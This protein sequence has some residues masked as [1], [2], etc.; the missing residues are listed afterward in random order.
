[1]NRPLHLSLLV[2]L[3]ALNLNSLLYPKIINTVGFWFTPAFTGKF[4]N[5]KFQYIV[6]NETR[7]RNL[8]GEGFEQ[9]NLT[10]DLG[11][12]MSK[13][14]HFW[15]GYEW[16]DNN[17][18]CDEDV[19]E[20]TVRESLVVSI[21]KSKKFILASRT[22][23]EQIRPSDEPRWRHEF[24][25]KGVI[26]FPNITKRITLLLTH[27]I[28]L[29]IVKSISSEEGVFRKNRFVVQFVADISKKY[30]IEFGYLNDFTPK[31]TVSTMNHVA[32]FNFTAKF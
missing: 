26:G 11:Y 32:F 24:R 27:E 3:A 5:P 25:Q 2:A 9:T 28:F 4:R 17:G 1:M 6:S 31:K 8:P 22:R 23:F 7:F 29:N 12:E 19:L 10:L 16:T 21:I 18:L 15:F 20:N 13:R 14:T 30:F